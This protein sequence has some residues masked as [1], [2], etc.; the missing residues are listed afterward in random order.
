MIDMRVS[1]SPEQIKAAFEP[2]K[3]NPDFQESR[4]LFERGHMPAEMIQAMCLRPEILSAFGRFGT[5]VYPGGLLERSVKELVII[6]A[7][8]KNQC[9]F[10]R[11]SHV[12]VA[13]MAGVC[14]DP[15]QALDDLGALSARDRLGV[16]YT[17]AVMADSNNVPEE[18]FDQLRRR[19][20]EPEIVELTFLVGFI[21][22]L[23]LFNNS[24]QVRY[25]G[26]YAGLSA[27]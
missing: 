8:R 13:K 16:T 18:L 6:E 9:Q 1:I 14:D 4:A 23:N 17:R 7:S 3:D 25:H 10:C 2:V 27:P 12:A 11:D 20:T 21:N 15:M 24:L 5:C 19:F 22:M 26:E